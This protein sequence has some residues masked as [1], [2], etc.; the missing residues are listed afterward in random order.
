MAGITRAPRAPRPPGRTVKAQPP[1]RAELGGERAGPS[2]PPSPKSVLTPII[3]GGK[4]SIYVEGRGWTPVSEAPPEYQERVEKPLELVSRPELGLTVHKAST[5]IFEQEVAPPSQ[6]KSIFEVRTTPKTSSVF[7]PET[8]EKE[9]DV[10]LRRRERQGEGRTI[11]PRELQRKIEEVTPTTP[12]I[13][14]L[15]EPEKLSI[16]VARQSR[17]YVPRILKTIGRIGKGKEES[18]IEQ[19]KLQQQIKDEAE[20]ISL[21]EENKALSDFNFAAKTIQKELKEKYEAKLAKNPERYEPINAEYEKEQEMKL[22]VVGDI[23][24][25]K[26]EFNV[27]K[28]SEQLG[29]KYGEAIPSALLFSESVYIGLRSG[30]YFTSPIEKPAEYGKEFLPSAIKHPILTAAQLGTGFLVGGAISK[31]AKAVKVITPKMKTAFDGLIKETKV[32]VLKDIGIDKLAKDIKKI[33]PPTLFEPERRKALKVFEGMP[34]PQKE[35]KISL[36]KALEFEKLVKF[37]TPTEVGIVKRLGGVET[38]LLS[39]PR[40]KTGPAPELLAQRWFDIEQK[41][42]RK[43]TYHRIVGLALERERAQINQLKATGQWGKRWSNRLESRLLKKSIQQMRRKGISGVVPKPELL[44]QHWL[45]IEKRLIPDLKKAAKLRKAA[46]RFKLVPSKTGIE[47]F[48]DILVGGK[49]VGE[50][51]YLKKM[52]GNIIKP[53]PPKSMI[54]KIADKRLLGLPRK[55]KTIS[56][57]KRTDEEFLDLPAQRLR[58]LSRLK[59]FEYRKLTA[60]RRYWED[61][62]GKKV[63][64]PPEERLRGE[65]ILETLIGRTKMKRDSPLANLIKFEERQKL[66]RGQ[67]PKE[68]FKQGEKEK[69]RFAFGNLLKPAQKPAQKQAE[70]QEQKY[71]LLPIERLLPKTITKTKERFKQGPFSL[72]RLKIPKRPPIIIF[73]KKKKAARQTK[74]ISNLKKL[75]GG[76]SRYKPSIAGLVGKKKIS[77]PQRF[78]SGIEIR[79]PLKRTNKLKSMLS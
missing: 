64:L 12:Y 71:K 76:P 15:I 79:R 7:T 77:R 17:L 3:L 73:P 65:H 66:D 39:I 23:A 32:A 2:A 57:F 62:L 13:K 20:T 28:R 11:F 24:S 47:G 21:Q 31:G 61:L 75:I 8:F 52:L 45:D 53:K 69:E 16:A 1:S 44:A 25:K 26:Y 74:L 67:K 43:P 35:F 56:I 19:S 72:E 54:A 55:Q 37:R 14:P 50:A 40:K 6:R 10:F 63:Y 27:N 49:K 4:P 48:K 70:K 5:N 60:I 51:N 46:P 30:R 78:F 18:M 42:L 58:G 59:E 29:K 33:S 68:R 41:L 9:R 34:K 36:G 38:K 22:S